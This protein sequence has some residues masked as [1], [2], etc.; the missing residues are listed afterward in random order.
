M[1]KW[2]N[3]ILTLVVTLALLPVSGFALEIPR[4]EAKTKF[5]YVFGPSGNPLDGKESNEFHLYVDVP[6]A[7]QGDVWLKVNDPQTGNGWD[8]GISPYDTKT[9]FSVTGSSLLD[10]K[11][12]GEDTASLTKGS[13]QFGPYTKDQGEKVGNKYRFTLAAK[14]LSGDDMNVFNVTV[15]PDQADVWSDKFTFIL[16][17]SHGDKMFFYP[18][19]P[20]DV[21][22]ITVRNFDLDKDGGIAQVTDPSNGEVFK[23]VDSDSGQWA[24]TK[25]TLT[26]AGER[27]LEYRVTTTDQNHGHAGIQVL[28]DKGNALPI[29]FKKG[30]W[31]APV[32]PVKAKKVAPAPAPAPKNLGCNQYVF[33]ARKSYDPNKGKLSYAWDFGDGTAS[34]QPYIVH[35]YEKGGNYR[36]TLTVSDNSGLHCEKNTTSQQIDVNTPPQ[37]ALAGP[38]L[39]CVGESVSLDAS[40]SKDDGGKMTYRW[41]FGDGT[42]GEG[43][44]VTKTY[45]KGGVYQVGV[46]VDDNAGTSCS[47]DAAKHTIRIN[48]APVAKAGKPVDMCV[49]NGKEGFTV[50]FDGSGSYDADKDNLDYRWNFGDGSTGEGAR[51]SHQYEKSGD[52]TAKLTVADNS[53]AACSSASD[54][55]PVKL[56]KAPVALAGKDQFVCAGQEVTLDGSESQADGS[57]NYSWNLGDGSTAEG[58]VVKHK[59][60]KG[61]KYKVM[62]TADDGKKTSCSTSSDAVTVRVNSKPQA[63]LSKVEAVCTGD[64]ISFDAGASSDPDGGS[65]KYSWDFGDGSAVSGGSKISHKYEKGGTYKVT[66]TVDDGTGSACSAS[67][68]TIYVKVN[69]PPKANAGPNLVCCQE[70]ASPFDASKSSDPDGDNLTY[71]WD[72]GDG[73]NSTDVKAQHAYAKSGNYKVTVTVNDNSGTACSVDQASFVANVNAQPVPIF[74]IK[75]K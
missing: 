49:R 42:T 69:T 6:E 68:D 11:V 57:S 10:K 30:P 45:E 31:V 16:L 44:Q 17:P 60:E 64:K 34:D 18:E 47:V 40:G 13:Y 5:F 20:A 29:Y 55:I 62:L 24:D 33:D 71:R 50:S 32:K 39:A 35:T 28:D 72:F 43:A 70:D 67:A 58:Q 26:G 59:Y 52:F 19:V 51:V 37:A 23:I 14:T 66:V 53:G 21:K 75:Q 25:I 22:N 8:A 48:T 12:F 3:R 15:K 4:Q 36:V 2:I 41:N 74:E 61:G 54:S 65:L 7:V 63:S 1:T 9:E 38:Q 27:R 56:N 73:S 46:N